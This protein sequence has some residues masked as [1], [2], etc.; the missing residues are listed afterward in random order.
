MFQ[1]ILKLRNISQT[2][3]KGTNQR[4]KKK[5]NKHDYIKI[6]LFSL[7]NT[8]RKVKSQPQ[9]GKKYL[10]PIQEHRTLTENKQSKLNR[11]GRQEIRNKNLIGK[12]IRRRQGGLTTL[13][14]KKN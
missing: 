3:D 4:K 7:K 1:M 9:A 14:V 5:I 13:A 6:N 2:E 10:Q 11:K 12:D 8:I